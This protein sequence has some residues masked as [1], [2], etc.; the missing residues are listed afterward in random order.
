VL[1]DDQ[2]RL[3][4]ADR[5]MEDEAAVGLYRSAEENRQIG[6]AFGLQGNVDFL[7]QRPQTHVDRPIDDHAQRATIVVFGD[8]DQVLEK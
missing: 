2:R 5:S 1:V 4:L 6:E 7:E 8:I 3:P